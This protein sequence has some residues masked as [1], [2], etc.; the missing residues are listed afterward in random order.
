MTLAEAKTL[1]GT[2]IFGSFAITL[3]ILA[4]ASKIA[5]ISYKKAHKNVK[6]VHR[7]ATKNVNIV[8]DIGDTS[9]MN[10]FE[11]KQAKEKLMKGLIENV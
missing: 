4:I 6:K 7:K 8:L 10:L 9:K 1:F 11:I 5:E 2:L 3:L